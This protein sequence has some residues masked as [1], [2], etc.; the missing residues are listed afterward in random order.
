MFHVRSLY[1]HAYSDR[2][3]S[4]DKE[5]TRHHDAHAQMKAEQDNMK[6]LIGVVKEMVHVQVKY[7]YS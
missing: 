4:D 5:T 1:V 3:A 2:Q 7:S 6:D